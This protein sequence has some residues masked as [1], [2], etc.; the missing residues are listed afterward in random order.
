MSGSGIWAEVQIQGVLARLPDR[1]S[2]KY[3]YLV[4]V[5]EELARY[6]VDRVFIK[7]RHTGTPEDQ[8]LLQLQGMFAEFDTRFGGF[9]R[10]ADYLLFW[11]PIYL[12]LNMF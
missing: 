5:I 1:L 7:A 6:G 2:R 11:L 3:A 8:L 9:D 12:E 4:L 10:L